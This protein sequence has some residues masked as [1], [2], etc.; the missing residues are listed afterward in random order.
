MHIQWPLTLFH[1]AAC[2]LCAREIMFLRKHSDPARLVLVDISAAA[3]N[4]DEQTGKS[5][6]ALQAKLHSHDAN[7]QWFI[8]L[9][10]TQASW[11]AGGFTKTA[12]LLGW[13]PLR[14]ILRPCY[15]LFAIVRPS[16]H[17]LPH[18][19]GAARC[20]DQYCETTAEK[21]SRP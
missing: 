11:L 17:W 19:D 2:P 10:A 20:K 12:W 15:K 1:D 14:W 8:G 9:D 7:G 16:L 18:P 5:L 6:E 13:T 21:Q 3:F 4:A